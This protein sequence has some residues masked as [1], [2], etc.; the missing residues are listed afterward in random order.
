MPTIVHIDIAADDMQ[1]AKKFY[2]SLF[3][4]KMA[5]PPGMDHYLLFETAGLNGEP[6]AGGGM[7]K[8][9]EPGQSVIN[10]IGVEDIDKYIGEV[11]RL[12]GKTV[13]P[14]MTVPGFGYL[15]VCQDTEGN[16]FGL[17]QDDSNAK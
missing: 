14:R 3:G 4:W 11:G 2:E 17:W 15:A 6:G 16:D 12:G 10:Y 1:R 5:S 13:Q 8:R 7:A 9:E